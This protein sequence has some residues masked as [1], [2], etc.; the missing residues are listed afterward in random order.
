MIID[1]DSKNKGGGGKEP[2]VEAL[3]VTENGIYNAPSGV[4]GYNPVEVNVPQSGGLFQMKYAEFSENKNPNIE[5]FDKTGLDL[6]GFYN[7]ELNSL[8]KDCAKIKKIDLSDT[9]PVTVVEAMHIFSGCSSLVEVNLTNWDLSRC[10]KNGNIYNNWSGIKYMFYGCTN[11]ENI[12]WNGV[13]FPS[14]MT[15]PFYDANLDTC[16]KLTV[17]SLMNLI[18]NLPTVTDAH[19]LKIGTVNINKLSDEQKAVAT[20]KNWSLY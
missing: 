18:E 13:K 6:N 12:I 1:F 20:G 17:D 5:T 3:S 10:K 11:I 7:N 9:V 4:D 8:F 19:Y 15:D 14:S 2:V 16:T